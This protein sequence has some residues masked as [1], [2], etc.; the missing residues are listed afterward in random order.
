MKFII[1]QNRVAASIV[2]NWLKN[3]D[4]HNCIIIKLL[5]V[6]S[7]WSDC[8]VVSIDYSNPSNSTSNI[9]VALGGMVNKVK[10]N[11]V[12]WLTT[13][14]HII[15]QTIILLT[16]N[17][18]LHLSL[19]KGISVFEI[20]KTMALLTVYGFPP[21]KFLF[22]KY[23]NGLTPFNSLCTRSKNVSC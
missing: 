17:D 10:A 12:K 16:S 4:I 19:Q 15:Q 5:F 20:E 14:V 7:K 13:L 22:S 9:K 11:I 6:S 3:C 2:L 21:L 8:N 1:N 18:I 23:H